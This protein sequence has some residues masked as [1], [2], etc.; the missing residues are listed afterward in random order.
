MPTSSFVP[1]DDRP[2]CPW[3]LSHP[4]YVAYHDDEWGV[5]RHDDA[6]LFEML[7]LEGAQAGLS[8][9]TILKR[10]ETYRAAF[11]HWDAQRVARYGAEDR[12]RLLAD[13]GIIRNRL[14]V[15]SAITNAGRVLDVAAEFGSF[16]AYVWRFT[17]GRTLRPSRPWRSMSELPSESAE[18]R[19]MSKDMARR[20]FRFVGPTIC[21]SFMQACGLVDDHLA[22]CFKCVV[23]SSRQPNK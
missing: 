17:E 1:P 3:C 7:V 18:S 9:L 12:A 4:L 16:D 11:E 2:R 20:G 13:T 22:D 14:K 15:D 19:A 5:P 23:A 10:R 21:Y 6:H 8:W